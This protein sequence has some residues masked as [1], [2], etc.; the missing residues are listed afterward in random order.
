MSTQQIQLILSNINNINL[1]I[2]NTSPDVIL[3]EVF[4]EYDLSDHWIDIIERLQN[5]F[6]GAW[7][8]LTEIQKHKLIQKSI[9]Y[10]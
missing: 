5:N 10:N 9:E 4:D 8:S 3:E 1:Y 2:H 7:N 6:L